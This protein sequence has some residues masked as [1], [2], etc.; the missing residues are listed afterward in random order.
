[1]RIFCTVFLCALAACRGGEE[2]S[3]ATDLPVLC[4]ALCWVEAPEIDGAFDVCTAMSV[5]RCK[6]DCAA[7]FSNANPLCAT[8]IVAEACF[9]GRCDAAVQPQDTCDHGICV[10]TGREGRCR[11]VEGDQSS[12][13]DCLR[14]VYPRR[15][16]ACD[17][18]YTRLNLCTGV[19]SAD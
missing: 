19:C 1:V 15:E 10:V 5:S 17:I 18:D 13:E 14:E 6:Q 7:S 12:R 8:C 4:E 9:G 11:Y 16:I 2:D 3:S